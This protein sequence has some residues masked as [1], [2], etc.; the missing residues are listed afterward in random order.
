MKTSYLRIVCSLALIALTSGFLLGSAAKAAPSAPGDTLLVNGDF[1]Q[2]DEH[3]KPV[4]WTPSGMGIAV[5]PDGDRTVLSLKT[6]EPGSASV[7]Q[8]L[9]LDSTWGTLRFTGTVRVNAITPGKEGWH[10]ARIALTFLDPNNTAT[11]LAAGF[12]TAPTDGWIPLKQD[13]Q[14]PAGATRVRIAP[15]I[16]SAVA[17][18]ELQGFRVV[19]IAR[20]GEGVDAPVPAGQSVTWGLEPVE[21]QGP[22]R[23][24]ICLNGLW[25]LQPA[26][27]PS[28]HEPQK[29]GWGWIRVPGSWRVWGS[30]EGPTR[31]SGPSWEGFNNDT[32]VAWYE[33]DIEIP[34][35]WAGRAVLLDLRRVSTDAA[36]FIDGR[37]VGRVAWPGGEVDLTTAVR[38]GSSY[39][40]RLKV[41]ATANAT[42]VT[43]FMGT[44]EG[45]VLTEK[46]ALSSSGLIGDALLISRPRGAFLTGCAIL[47]S[48][49]ER[50]LAVEV[51]YADLPRAGQVALTVVAR[52]ADGREAKRFNADLSASAGSGVLNASWEWTDPRL[53]DIDDPHL[54]TLEISAQG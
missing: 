4:G 42:E 38:P 19:M 18:W 12:W 15:A 52:N 40:L 47:T 32:P 45:Q 5:G 17:D 30:F 54:Y 25:R 27:G 29:T 46:F 22:R 9:A 13:V 36:V 14:I 49:R 34:A 44:G 2:L 8:E 16:Y 11:H 1:K 31:A 23:G 51:N 35:A 28:T 41:V 33:R 37:E 24:V 43:R 21:E 6:P 20:R 26:L 48:V 7:V 10:D 3:G 50:K 53:W 39:R